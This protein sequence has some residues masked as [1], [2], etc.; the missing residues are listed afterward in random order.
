MSIPSQKNGKLSSVKIEDKNTKE[1]FITAFTKLSETKKPV[2]TINDL[3]IKENNKGIHHYYQLFNKNVK[4]NFEDYCLAFKNIKKITHIVKYKDFQ[5]WLLANAIF[6]NNRLYYWK[7]VPSTKCDYCENNCKQTIT[8]LLVNCPKT[9]QLW[10]QLI[11]FIE[12]CTQIN[13]NEITISQQT[14]MLNN[15]HP[16][17]G[18]LMNLLVLIVKQY[19]CHAGWRMPWSG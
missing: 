15:V 16:K 7:K 11:K 14:I 8:H 9:K 4:T 18:H 6:T 1:V 13:T 12:K 17:P 10:V 19:I 3:L 5:Y 2:K